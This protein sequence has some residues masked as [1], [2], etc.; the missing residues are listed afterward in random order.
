M[1]YCQIRTG[2]LKLVV[3]NYQLTKSDVYGNYPLRFVTQT[4]PNI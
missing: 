3:I 4:T 1:G 2:A